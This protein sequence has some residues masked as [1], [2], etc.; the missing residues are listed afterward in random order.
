MKRALKIFWLVIVAIAALLFAIV[1]LLQM[2]P[3]Q[4]LLARKAGNALEEVLNGRITISKIHLTPFNALVIKDLVLLDDNP[5]TFRGERLDTAFRAGSVVAT[6]SL[7]GLWKKEGLHIHRASIKEAAFLLTSE[8]DG[9]NLQRIFNLGKQEASGEKKKPG[10]VFDIGKVQIEDFRFRLIDTRKDAPVQEYGIHWTDLDLC[11]DHLDARDVTLSGGSLSGI[12]D[13]GS[14]HEKSGYRISSLSG[15]IKVR[16]GKTVIEHLE[17]VD[18][19]S[20]VNLSEYTM[21]YTDA[22][23]FGDFLNRVRLTGIIA[24]SRISLGSLAYFA[25]ALRGM[26]LVLNVKE[27]DVEGTVSDLGINRLRF[28]EA[29]SGIS[30]AL[31]GSISGL[32][33]IDLLALDARIE[34]AEFTSEGIGKLMKSLSPASKADPGRF[35]DGQVFRFDGSANGPLNDLSLRGDLSTG[36]GKL[37]ADVDLKNLADKRKD[38]QI[39]GNVSTLDLDLGAVA[40]IRQVGPCSMH[41]TLHAT[42]GKEGP[43]IRIDTVFID[44]LNALDYDY[45]RI[46]GAGTYSQNAFDGRIICNDPNLNFLFQGIFTLSDKTRNGLYKFYA[47]IG[48]ADLQALRLDRRGVS[49]VSGQINANY[50]NI[51]KGD[52]IGNLAVLDLRLEN[53]Q[54]VHDIGDIRIKSYSNND[55]HRMNLTSRFARGSYV[56][57]KALTGILGDVKALTVGRELP[58]LLKGGIAGWDGKACGLSLDLHDSRELLS[59]VLPGLYI[60]DSTSLKLNVEQ[61]GTVKAALRSPRIALGKNYLRNLDLN[62]NNSDGSLNGAVSSSEMNVATLNFLNNSFLLYADNNRIGIGYTYDNEEVL[63]DKGELY[64]TGELDRD[65]KGE[66]VIRGKTLPSNIYYND[67]GWNISPADITLHGKDFFV[68]NLKA[69]CNEQSITIGGGFSKTR[70]DT[71]SLDL[72]RFDMGLLNKLAGQDL[73]VEGLATGHALV[74]SPNVNMGLLMSLACDSTKIAGYSLGTLRVASSWVDEESKFHFTARNELNG[75][76]TLDLSGDFFT[77]AKTIDASVGLNRMELGYISPFLSSVFSRFEGSVSGKVHLRGPLG[78][79]SLSSE[80]TRFDNVLM[81]VDFTRVNYHV[82]GPFHVDNSGLFFDNLAVKDDYDGKAT[83]SGGILFKRL[84]DFRMDTRLDM[85]RIEALNTSGED[86]PTFNGHV[87]ASGEVNITGPFHAILLDINA[88]TAKQGSLH[89]PLDN[90]SNAGNSDL[91]TFKEVDR[92]IYVDP[93]DLLVN[94]PAAAGRKSSDFGL[95]LRID[96]NPGVETFVEIDRAAGNY[97]SGRGQGRIDIA[98]RPSTKLFTINGAYTLA[99]GNFHFNAMDIAQRDFTL[100]DGSSIRF[101]GDIMDSDLDIHGVYT[102][103][104]SVATLIADTSSVSTRR[105]VNCG[106][107]ISGRLREPRLGFSI[108]V[109]DLDPTTQSRVESA[110]NTE[111][112]VQR[113]FLSLLISGSFMPDEQSG[114]VNNTNML[115]SNVAEIM[116]GQLNNI[117][118][119]LDIPLDLGLNY[120]SSESGTNIFDV[121]LSTQLFNNRVIV[122]GTVGNR[123]YSNSN[124]QGDMVGNLDIEIKLDRPGQLRLSLFSHSTDAY[125]SYLDNTQR[126]GIGIAYQRE[127]NTFGEFFRNLFR[128]RRKREEMQQSAPMEKDMKVIGIDE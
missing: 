10:A 13:E 50:M 19:H 14:L 89:I 114:V 25:P 7:K 45:T 12:L 104:A 71:L 41:G 36:T 94:K 51:S 112:K 28:T 113:Q 37:S 90:A 99:S 49:K 82:D 85:N 77:G 53:G 119:K 126:N 91:L 78:S 109:P 59:F 107:G 80:G 92:T 38:L 29:R 62:F 116:A 15:R 60:A 42:L 21:S 26:D 27:G 100:S 40:G 8:P 34:D 93:Y 95:R 73:G 106:I 124:A 3:V 23:S 31:E 72:V 52:L 17:L 9:G 16:P 58:A 5:A 39:V 48:Y 96:A 32:P 75:G 108:D 43:E 64:L 122:N 11:A 24:D 86:N 111:D 120:Q 118:Q 123:E 46:V 81:Q 70:R 87:F 18:N 66:L 98:V 125:T 61:D 105:T 69:A 20:S 101:N 2:S 84:K 33:R 102:T 97:L 67:E 103:K 35:A 1:I 30:G 22:A 76:N 47:N 65:E 110:L 127:F 115:Y 74:I 63:A 44:R 57:D 88:R 55:I 117:L 6:F 4:T 83:A 56:G 79:L 121:A 54:G 68:D 128:S